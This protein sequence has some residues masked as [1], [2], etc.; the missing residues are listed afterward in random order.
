MNF[1]NNGTGDR[2]SD[3]RTCTL[4]PESYQLLLTGIRD[5]WDGQQL[6]IEKVRTRRP[7]LSTEQIDAEMQ[8]LAEMGLPEW[9]QPDFWT[10]DLDKILLAGLNDD[11][12]GQ[13]KA[14]SKVLRLHPELRPEA[15]WSRLRRL[16]RTHGSGGQHQG[17][18]RWTAEWDAILAEHCQLDGVDAAVAHVENITHYPHDAVRRRAARLGLVQ[19]TRAVPRPWTNAELKFLVESLQHEPV[20]AIAKELRRSEKAIWRKAAEIGVSAKC[21]EGCTVTEVLWHLHVSHRRLRLWISAGWIKVGRN[22]RI[23]DRSLRA[24][25]REHRGEIEWNRLNAEAR[26][27]LLEFGIDAENQPRARAAGRDC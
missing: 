27:W 24:F 21:I 13:R 6:A 1:P 3:S 15:A 19:P 8:A 26:D 23:T 4:D 2:L 17:R 18:F 22:R 5:G 12:A 20:R 10:R 7:D 16:R 9:L 14:V 11:A 25:L